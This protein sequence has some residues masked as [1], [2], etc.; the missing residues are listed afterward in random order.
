MSEMTADEII[1][2]LESSGL[3]WDVGHTGSLR[4]CRIWK[5]PHVIGR[6]RPYKRVP[7]S[8]MLTKA[9]AS[10]DL[11]SAHENVESCLPNNPGKDHV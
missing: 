9:I 11:N 7:L 3:G 4:E 5:W 2:N 6:Y 8:E 1:A 10:I